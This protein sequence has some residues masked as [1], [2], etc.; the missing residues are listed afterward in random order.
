MHRQYL[1]PLHYRKEYPLPS[2]LNQ[3][4]HNL[5]LMFCNRMKVVLLLLKGTVP[6]TQKFPIPLSTNDIYIQIPA[7]SNTCVSSSNKRR[8]VYRCKVTSSIIQEHILTARIRC[9]DRVRLLEQVCHSLIVVSYC[10]PGSAQ[11]HAA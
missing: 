1:V 2:A 3:G 10:V 7:T 11:R 5:N 8:Q 9:I 4:W 6:S